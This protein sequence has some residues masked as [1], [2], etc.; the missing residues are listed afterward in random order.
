MASFPVQPTHHPRKT[1][2]GENKSK[3]EGRRE[4]VEFSG[5]TVSTWKDSLSNHETIESY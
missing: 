3:H 1:I 5:H 4:K 2:M